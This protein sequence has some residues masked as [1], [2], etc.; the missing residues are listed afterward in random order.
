MF[1]DDDIAHEM[2]AIADRDL[3]KGRRAVALLEAV[4]QG[5][6]PRAAGRLARELNAVTADP[7][8]GLEWFRFTECA[9]SWLVSSVVHPSGDR[10]ALAEIVGAFLGYSRGVAYTWLDDGSADPLADPFLHA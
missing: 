4:R 8:Q 5:Y 10:A 6:G 2:S 9:T 7:D 3:S 1:A